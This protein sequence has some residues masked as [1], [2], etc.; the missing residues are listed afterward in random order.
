MKRFV[1]VSMLVFISILLL[2]GC[3]AKKNEQNDR[4]VT[5]LQNAIFLKNDEQKNISNISIG[6]ISDDVYLATVTYLNKWSEQI[7]FFTYDDNTISDVKCFDE[8]DGVFVAKE[9][10]ELPQGTYLALYVA[11]HQGNGSTYLV[12]MDT[13]SMKCIFENTI[14]Y[15][16]E[17]YVNP[18]WLDFESDGYGYS[19]IYSDKYLKLE[20]LDVNEDGYIDFVFSGIRVLKFDDD[21]EP[22]NCEVIELVFLYNRY[23]GCWEKSK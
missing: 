6:N 14:D 15:H 8:L 5:V 12:D 17:G 23:S 4:F 9:K 10:I 13:L 22:I 7:F 18:K 20:N 3:G 1:F 19:F 2:N 21:N 11:N 16:N